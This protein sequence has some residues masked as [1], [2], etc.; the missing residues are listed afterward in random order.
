MAR[1]R[2]GLRPAPGRRP[3]CWRSGSSSWRGLG[4]RLVVRSRFAIL[5]LIA[6]WSRGADRARRGT[7]RA[8]CMACAADPG[9]P[10]LRDGWLNGHPA[11]ASSPVD[12]RG[13]FS[14]KSGKVPGEPEVPRAIGTEAG[15]KEAEGELVG[16]LVMACVDMHSGSCAFAR[17]PPSRLCFRGVVSTQTISSSTVHGRGKSGRAPDPD[18][19]ARGLP[20]RRFSAAGCS[21][22]SRP[23]PASGAR[24]R[25]RATARTWSAR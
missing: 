17:L 23:R 16:A 25:A 8:A 5:L 14:A 4:C 24:S 12:C 3:P 21:A 1:S 22:R 7:P 11:D 10:A 9:L 15:G 2:F 13:V 20:A 6:H 19:C 18:P